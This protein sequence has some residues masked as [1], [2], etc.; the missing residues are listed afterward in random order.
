MLTDV[1]VDRDVW[2]W[3]LAGGLLLALLYVVLPYGLLASALYVAFTAVA[4]FA[5]AVAVKIRPQLVCPPAWLLI[6]CALGLA[7]GGHA[8]WYWLDLLGMEPF[9]SLA[10]G[11]YLAIYPLFMVALWKLGQGAGRDVGALSDALIV[12][13]AAA[14]P[15]WALLIAPYVNDP[16]LSMAQLLVS[17]AYP[18]ADLILLPLILRLIFLHRARVMAHLFLLSGMLA[19]L[20]ADMLYAHGNTVGWYAPG[21]MTDALWL[22]A[23]VLIVAAIWHPSASVELRSDLSH[24]EMSGRRILVLGSASMLAPAVILSTAGID[25]GVVRIAAIASILLFLLVMHRMGGLM[26]ET[27]RQADKLEKLTRTDP[28]TGAA[29]R[30]YLDEALAREIARARRLSSPMTLVFMDLDHFKRFNDSYGHAAGDAL[31][32]DLVAAWRP[33]LRES[34]LLARTGGEEFVV[35]LPDTAPGD[36]YL[37]VE[38]LRQ[39]APHGQTCSA[40]IAEL[41]PGDSADELMARADRAMYAAKRGG[42]DRA[43]LTENGNRRAADGQPRTEERAMETG[44]ETGADQRN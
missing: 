10:D 33:I 7:A 26:R 38:R 44:S 4:A 36:A 6:A 31:L 32:E 23:Y 37:V 30:R 20:V 9:P 8:I 5:V 3:L 19:Y 22:V 28:L 18:V 16:D 14:V 29:N 43:V 15:G 42:R 24:V 2:R 12:G 21:G 13:V 1:L 40:G 11:F 27:H 17:T 25:E 39:C 35:L 41:K 34:D